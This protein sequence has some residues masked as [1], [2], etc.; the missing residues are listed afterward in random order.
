MADTRDVLKDVLKHT[1]G[2]DIFDV[3]KIVG[4]DKETLIE[5]VDSDKTVVFKGKTDKP[6]D[7]F[8]DQTVGLSRMSVLSGFANYDGFTDCSAVKQDGTDSLSELVFS[9]T[10][11]STANYR[12][13]KAEI[14]NTH[15]KEIKFKGATYDIDITPSEKNIQDIAYFNGVLGS[16]E[17]T[18][19]PRTENKKLFF[20]IGDQSGDRTKILVT[21]NVKGEIKHEHKWPLSTVLKIL[22][23]GLSGTLS[24]SFDV[25]GL[26]KIEIASGLG[27]YTYLMPAQG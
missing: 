22:K 16:F 15:L 3:V 1:H 12:F 27:V 6:V 5:T 14:V 2:L 20:Y 21:D 26:I 4:T 13:M 10:E 7:V 17:G 11:G 25:K 19:S 9:N 8:K 23:L 18:F 24:M